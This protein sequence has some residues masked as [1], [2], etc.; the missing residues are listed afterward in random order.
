MGPLWI[1]CGRAFRSVLH[2]VQP[3]S[4]RKTRGRLQS[5][6]PKDKEAHD[7]QLQISATLLDQ[8][9]LTY[10]LNEKFYIG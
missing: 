1:M 3:A 2:F 5:H 10:I 7:I 4:G 6:R 8:N 9:F